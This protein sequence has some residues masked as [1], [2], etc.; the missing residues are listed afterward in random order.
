MKLDVIVKYR[1]VDSEIEGD[2]PDSCKP[3]PPCEDADIEGSY[4]GW[5]ANG[6]CEDENQIEYMTQLCAKTCGFC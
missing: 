3:P 1:V 2:I 5:L 6:F 4:P